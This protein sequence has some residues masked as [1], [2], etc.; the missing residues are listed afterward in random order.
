MKKFIEFFQP[1]ILPYFT[2][3]AGAVAFLLRLV[4]QL[5]GIDEKGLLISYHAAG[6]LL[7]IVTALFLAGLFLCVRPLN[8]VSRYSKLFPESMLSAVGCVL[9]AAG[10]L[11]TALEQAFGQPDVLT[12]VSA[13]VAAG[14]A[15]CLVRIGMFRQ[16][17]GHPTYKLH[18]VVTVYFMLQLVCQYRHWSPEP[19]FLLYFFPLL[20]SIFLTLTA[21]QATCLDAKKGRRWQYAFFNQAALYFCFVALVSEYWV[22]YLAMGLWTGTNLCSMRISRHRSDSN[23]EA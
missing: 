14:A 13:V 11:Y 9:A 6:I 3:I 23:K 16:K 10:I 1:R 21:Y 22:F 12:I 17:G 2:L 19:Q 8:G 4:L 18:A 20:S 15:I 5:T 7:Y